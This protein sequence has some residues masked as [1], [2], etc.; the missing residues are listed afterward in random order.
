MPVKY[1]SRI[2]S[3]SERSF[4][5]SKEKKKKKENYNKY[6]VF[7]RQYSRCLFTTAAVAVL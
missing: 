1:L 6:I 2:C 7:Q 5:R 3:I 4:N